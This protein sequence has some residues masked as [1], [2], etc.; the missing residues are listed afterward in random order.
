MLPLM[1]SA[2]PSRH[3]PEWRPD[4]SWAPWAPGVYR[5]MGEAPK[6]FRVHRHAR[7]W[8]PNLGQTQ[9]QLAQQAAGYAGTAATTVTS[10]LATIGTVSAATV[11]LV[12]AVVAAGTVLANLM[13]KLFSGCGQSCT[14]TSDEAN[15]VQSALAQN[16]AAYLAIPNGQRT[17]AIQAAALANFNNTW[18]Q[19][20]QYC[21][22]ASFGQAGQN[23]ID[24]REQGACAY[25]TSPGG[26]Q[27]DSSGNWS[28]VYPGANGS[29][30]TCWNYFVG[31]HDPI[32]NDPTVVPNAAGTSTSAAVSA[33]NSSFEATTGMSS[34]STP[35]LA[36]LLVIG[37]IVIGALVLL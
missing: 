20:V 32:A 24:Q 21:G 9:T 8:R 6:P 5:G 23:C 17:Q 11:P 33:T 3:A 27:Q 18:A 1:L 10:L 31:F 15:E 12:G 37:A 26:W 14:L 30:S 2:H 16:L 34:T 7:E 28:Y 25:K 13:I 36:P 35:N 29:G 19:L 4:Y 22:S